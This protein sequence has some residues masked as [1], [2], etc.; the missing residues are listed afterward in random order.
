M[1]VCVCV[2]VCV[3]VVADVLSLADLFSPADDCIN[4][5]CLSHGAVCFSRAR[6]LRQRIRNGVGVESFIEE[7]NW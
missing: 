5:Y 4:L 7:S 3:C 2:S 1:C 6:L